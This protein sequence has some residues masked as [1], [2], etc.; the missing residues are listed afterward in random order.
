MP[1]VVTWAGALNAFHLPYGFT[2]TLDEA[3]EVPPL[4]SVFAKDRAAMRLDCRDGD[5]APVSV[6]ELPLAA[7]HTLR[8]ILRRLGR[9][10]EDEILERCGNCQQDTTLRPSSTLELGPYR[11]GELD[12]PDLDAFFNFRGVNTLASL[13]GVR[14]EPRSVRQALPFYEAL[15]AGSPLAI[16]P[17]LIRAM[18]V[19]SLGE[20]TSPE[21]IA[22]RVAESPEDALEDLADLFEEAHYP[23]RL[24]TPHRCPE[25]GA[26]LW[27]PAPTERGLGHAESAAAHRV[28]GA[29]QGPPFVTPAEFEARVRR[30]APLVYGELGVTAVGL[31]VQCGPADTDEGGTPLLG[32]YLPEAPDA[33]IPSAAEIT[34][35]YRTFASWWEEDGPY[36]WDAEVE[37]TLRH[38]LEHHLAYLA[39]SDPTDEAERAL[40]VEEERRLVG[41]QETRRR[42]LR[43]AAR[44]AREFLAVTW[45]IWLIA[46]AGVASYCT[47]GR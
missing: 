17:A 20:L 7:F 13:G 24:T 31:T 26:T 9:V 19:V 18:G 39:G 22:E 42:E 45:W 47:V 30:L 37:A 36:D 10:P 16:D 40:L 21:L 34:L 46:A 4:P 15:D 3:R 2:A 14:L 27:C 41:A 11:N 12:D 6:L 32:S 8:V 43:G 5:G 44:G 25:C 33:L 1:L 38:E 29:R 23:R 35:Y 28:S